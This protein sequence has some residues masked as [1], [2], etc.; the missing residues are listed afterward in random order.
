MCWATGTSWSTRSFYRVSH[1]ISVS[2]LRPGDALLKKG[3]HIRLFYGWVDDAHT[4]Y[5]AY[6][7]ANGII[8][9][10]RIHSLADDLDFG[11]VPTRYDRIQASPKPSNVL[12]NGTF[13]TWARSWGSQ[14]EQPVWWQASGPWWQPLVAHR[15]DTYRSACSSLRLINPSD[16]PASYTELS[17]SAPIVAGVQYRLSAWAKTAF[18]PNGLE[19]KLTYLNAAGE[20]VAETSS[21]G[22]RFGIEGAPFKKMSMLTTSPPDAVR[23]LA[24]VRLAGGGTA[25]ASGTIV[26]GT[27]VTLDDISLS[28]PQA[29][30]GI[31]ASRKRAYSGTTAV[32]S[33]AVTPIRAIGSRAVIYV[34]RPGSSWK[35]LTTTPVHASGDAGGW[36][37]KFVFTRSMRRGTYRFKTI[38]PAIPG[39]LG[40]TSRT[41]S[42]T[43]K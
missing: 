36:K 35:Q 21:T 38:Q 8:A 33:G 26:P 10:C 31:N 24:T 12:K 2:D 4:S 18:D 32:L 5:V 37:G 11:Y 6:E 16:D 27:S 13:N 22:A 7:S 9:G 29:S 34:Q 17:Q 43:L 23:A 1:R 20:S 30:V 41:V 28:R 42:V 14:P 39:Y 15:K 19:L 3:Y 25:D 40:A